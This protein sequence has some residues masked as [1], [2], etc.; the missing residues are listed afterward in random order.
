MA[1]LKI[2]SIVAWNEETNQQNPAS[3]NGP[4]P[5]N[6]TSAEIPPHSDPG[7]A[8][9]EDEAFTSEMIAR[10]REI[11]DQAGSG[12]PNWDGDPYRSLMDEAGSPHSGSPSEPRPA[13]PDAAS[14]TTESSSTT[15]AVPARAGE[16]WTEDENDLLV[17]EVRAGAN[18]EDIAQMHGRSDGAIR[19]RLKKV[20]L[21]THDSE[22]VHLFL[23]GG[24]S[25]SRRDLRRRL[26]RASRTVHS[27]RDQ[28]E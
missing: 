22:I 26:D 9:A 25:T 19:S 4:R 28:P 8:S 15:S 16:S 7:Q 5:N 23:R 20:N 6:E 13:P 10:R 24:R 1:D 2:R 12:I 17:E 21:V 27:Q 3:P 11:L 14:P 18:V